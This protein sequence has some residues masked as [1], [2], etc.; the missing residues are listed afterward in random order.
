MKKTDIKQDAMNAMK[1][2]PEGFVSLKVDYAFVSVM[3][4]M[5]SSRLLIK[6]FYSTSNSPF[7]SLLLLI[8]TLQNI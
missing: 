1:E 6:I 7:A 4:S 3:K 8:F 2:R 5:F